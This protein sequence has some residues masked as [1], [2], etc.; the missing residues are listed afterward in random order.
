LQQKH[1]N[2]Q[3]KIINIRRMAYYIYSQLASL[4]KFVN[5]VIADIYSR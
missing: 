1:D 2:D 4:C 3:P 5:I